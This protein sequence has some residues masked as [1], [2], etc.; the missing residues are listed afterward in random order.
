MKAYVIQRDDGS[1]KALNLL[2]ADYWDGKNWNWLGRAHLFRS[3][4][5]AQKAW[6]K[7]GDVGAA[8]IIVRVDIQIAD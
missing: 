5:E 7:G 1:G 2:K 3:L 6:S 8:V 4:V